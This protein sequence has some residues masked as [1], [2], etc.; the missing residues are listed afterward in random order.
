MN[1]VTIRLLAGLTA[2]LAAGFLCLQVVSGRRVPLAR[3]SAPITGA[4]NS[5]DQKATLPPAS[6]ATTNTAPKAEALAR[7]Q[8]IEAHAAISNFAAWTKDFLSGNSSASAARGEALAWKRREAMRELI[9]TD[10]AKALELAAPFTWRS[11]LPASV[12]RHFEQWVDGIGSLLVYAGTDFE[13]SQ[14]TVT[15]EVEL[16]GQMYRAF[17][18]GS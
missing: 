13:R 6:S 8:V 3:P 14:V 11:E 1:R 7:E 4:A 15:R 18:Y 10:P 9:E 2:L 5:S 12:T 17:V 16:A